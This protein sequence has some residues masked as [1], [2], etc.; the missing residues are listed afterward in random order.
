MAVMVDLDLLRRLSEGAG[1]SGSEGEVAKLL[2]EVLRPYADSVDRDRLGNVIAFKEGEGPTPRPRVLLSAHMDEIGLLVTGWEDGG[3]LRFSTVGGVDI[4]TLL[5]Q[6]V[7]VHGTRILP[8]VIG[9]KPPHLQSPAE[10]KEAIDGE[11]MYIDTGLKA[12]DELERLV[13]IG[14]VVTIARK[15]QVLAQGRVAGKA[16]DNRAGVMVL[17]GCLKELMAVKHKADVYAV[18]TVQEEVG[19]R[20]AITSS[21]GINPDLGIAIDV[22][23]GD[24]LGMAEDE[25]YPL[26]K[27]PAI[28]FGPHVH[29][30]LYR[31]LRDSAERVGIT[32]QV[33][34]SPTPAGTDAWGIQ[35]ARRGIP[36]ALISIPLRYMHTSVETLSMRDVAETI[37][38][39]LAFIQGLE[40]AFVEGLS[41]Y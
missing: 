35:I 11:K 15:L 9:A 27:G 10:R 17:V 4:R 31:A 18:A 23:H 3:F 22:C 36:T 38:L 34:P 21:H 39:L 41:C 24:M 40:S 8:G 12:R 19:I 13:P 29:H 16:L 20:G 30:Q 28:G 33:E 2:V 25:G 37:R 6:E 5:G 1:V 7:I 14:S 26:D 32:Y